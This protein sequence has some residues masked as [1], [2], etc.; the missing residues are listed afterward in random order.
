MPVQ[1]ASGAADDRLTLNDYNGAVR[2]Q[3]QVGPA[4]MAVRVGAYHE[5]RSA[6]LVGANSEATG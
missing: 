6:G 5:D 2:M 1:E 4:L 3:T